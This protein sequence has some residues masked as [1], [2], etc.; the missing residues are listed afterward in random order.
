M[1]KASSDLTIDLHSVVKVYKG[2]IHALRGINMQVKRGEIFG[3]LG[4]NGAGK[5]TLVKIMLTVIRPTAAGGT[6]LGCP[7]GHKPAMAR[8]GYLPEDHR[9]PPY[10]TARQAMEYYAALSNVD[11]AERKRRTTDLLEMVG[12]SEAADRKMRTFS[13]GMLQ[14]V[15]L[16]QA[17]VHD[18]D[19]V[20]LDE[21]TDGLDPIGRRDIRNVLTQ[22]RDLGKTVFINSHLLSE[23]EMVCDRVA[24]LKSGSVIR[25]GRLDELTQ[26]RQHYEIELADG[27]VPAAAALVAKAV[28]GK[29]VDVQNGHICIQ[30]ADAAAI[31]PGLDALR[32]EGLVIAGVQ[33]ARQSLEEMFIET[34]SGGPSAQAPPLLPALSGTGRK[35]GAR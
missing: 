11:R 18:P 6:V 16:A 9:F 35:G 3:L 1:V 25:Q 10:L 28:G 24:I 4:P 5:T 22:L 26:G 12:M 30:D 8:V 33:S 32:R 34:V 21:P 23:L 20:I 31:Q 29:D 2:K 17:L 13:K 15:G 19:L 27:D 7:V 14:R